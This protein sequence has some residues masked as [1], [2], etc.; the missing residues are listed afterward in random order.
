MVQQR[1]GQSFGMVQT[2]NAGDHSR[3]A[4]IVTALANADT[5]EMAKVLAN[6][7]LLRQAVVAQAQEFAKQQEQA[8]VMQEKVAAA[9]KTA[10]SSGEK[11]QATEQPTRLKRHAGPY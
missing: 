8:G 10:T 4:I 1:H 9:S 2:E 11:K 3:L 6:D 7:P 5:I